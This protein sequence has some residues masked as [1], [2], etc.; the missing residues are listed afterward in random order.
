MP[1]DSR[2]QC[3]RPKF[4]KIRVPGGCYGQCIGHTCTILSCSIS[5]AT[6]FLFRAAHHSLKARIVCEIHDMMW[7]I[8]QQDPV[9]VVDSSQIVCL[10]LRCAK[11]FRSQTVPTAKR[12]IMRHMAIENEPKTSPMS[13]S[14]T[15]TEQSSRSE[16][17]SELQARRDRQTAKPTPRITCAA[18]LAGA[19]TE[20]FLLYS[21]YTRWSPVWASVVALL[22]SQGR[23]CSH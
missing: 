7:N 10:W 1:D 22:H 5:H 3:G 14:I 11:K 17:G 13:T 9:L 6:Q 15:C 4:T 19:S 21:L 8:Q 18:D 12:V 16:P 2:S 23:P 20:C